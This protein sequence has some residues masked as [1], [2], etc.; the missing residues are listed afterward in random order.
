MRTIMADK[1]PHSEFQM[2]TIDAWHAVPHIPSRSR[3]RPAVRPYDAGPKLIG[4]PRIGS[5]LGPT[6]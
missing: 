6:G 3:S 4:S 1:Q 5:K 2:Q